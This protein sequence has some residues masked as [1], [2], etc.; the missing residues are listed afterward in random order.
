MFGTLFDDLITL[1]DNL[2]AG[3]TGSV[4]TTSLGAL[5]TAMDN[6]MASRADL[7]ARINRFESSRATSE[8]ADV[9]LQELK[10][11]IEEV[12][13]ASAIV[14]LTGQQTA[15]EAAMGAIGRSTNLTLLNFLR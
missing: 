11:D 4:I 3:A 2:N 13:L 9:N 14:Q 15:L 10:R 6:V 8:Q 7:G 12:D 5:D 1:R